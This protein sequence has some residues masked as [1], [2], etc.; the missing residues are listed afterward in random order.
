MTSTLQPSAEL[1]GHQK[2]V[3]CVKYAQNTFLG[4][5]ILASGSEDNTCRIW[6]LRTQQVVKGIKGLQD[7]VSSV[8]FA[9]TSDSSLFYLSSGK[10][11]LVYDLRNTGMIVSETCR[12]YEFSGDEINSI[13]I[14]QK[15][16]FL[17]TG[18]DNGEVKIVDLVN[19]KIYKKLNKKH[20]NVIW[21][22]GLDCK[23]HQ[24]DF[25]KGKLLDIYDTAPSEPSSTQMFN[26]P[27]VYTIE[28]SMDG[29][30]VAAGLGDASIQIDPVVSRLEDGH[31]N[32]VN[33]LSFL[34]GGDESQE[35][36]LLSGSVN[37]SLALW[38]LPLHSATNQVKAPTMTAPSDQPISKY[39]L[40][41]S[42]VRLNQLETYTMDGKT[43]TL[44][45]AA[46][47]GV[48]GNGGV[49]NLYSLP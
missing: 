2:P 11:V 47:G 5:H 1:K 13:D 14:N 48:D 28:N 42:V 21:S 34:P 37:G 15:Q 17:A 18:D 26:P 24:W 9:P 40:D 39:Q 46:V 44:A 41:A 38:R 27:F 31:S 25:S 6:D 29:N 30:W 33:C 12:E 36:L 16:S 22:G 43:T 32:M 3:L 35:P 4:E 8:A 7:P 49:L 23:V 19:H 45:A 10:K 20:R